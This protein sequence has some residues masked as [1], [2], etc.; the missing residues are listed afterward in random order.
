MFDNEKKKKKINPISEGQG[1]TLDKRRLLMM[2][3]IAAFEFAQNLHG[4]HITKG[5]NILIWDELRLQKL[6]YGG[7]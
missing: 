2:N 5:R 3:D 4:N 7:P 1:G 6:S